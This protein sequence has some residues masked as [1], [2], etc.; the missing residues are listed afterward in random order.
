MDEE[1]DALEERLG[2]E[3]PANARPKAGDYGFDLEQTLNSVLSIRTHIP[4]DAFTADVGL[5]SDEV[6]A[7]ST[8][9]AD[10]P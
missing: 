4:D 8:W 7:R 2:P 6:M 10:C 3:I 9:Q 1:D 5:P